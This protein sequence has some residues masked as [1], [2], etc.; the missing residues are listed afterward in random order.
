MPFSI[1]RQLGSVGS[2]S[3][4]L[5]INVYEQTKTPSMPRRSVALLHHTIIVC[6]IGL[7]QEGSG[8]IAVKTNTMIVFGTYSSSMYPSVCVEAVEKLGELVYCL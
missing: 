4:V 6:S 7:L 2:T 5:R 1:Q 3:M 8:F